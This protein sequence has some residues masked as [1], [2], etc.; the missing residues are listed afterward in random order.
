MTAALSLPYSVQNAFL[1][2]DGCSGDYQ[3]KGRCKNEGDVPVKK[4]RGNFSVSASW[5]STGR[6]EV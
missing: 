6:V 1:E 2:A 3:K 5:R 4:H